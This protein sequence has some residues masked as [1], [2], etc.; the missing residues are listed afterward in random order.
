MQQSNETRLIASSLNHFKEYF[1]VLN[2]DTNRAKRGPVLFFLSIKKEFTS[3][4]DDPKR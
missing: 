2:T 4:V 3:A 1:V